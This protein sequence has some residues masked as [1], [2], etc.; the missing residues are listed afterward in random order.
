MAV[1]TQ[2][3]IQFIFRLSFGISVAMAITPSRLVTSGFYRIHLWVVMGLNTLAAI[4]IYSA[5]SSLIESQIPT[6]LVLSGAIGTAVLCYV[7]AALWLFEKKRMGTNLLW[8]AALLTLLCAALA[9]PWSRQTTGWGI[10]MALMDLTSGGLLLGSTLTA[11][12]LGHWYLNTP[13]MDLVPLRRLILWMG[14]SVVARSFLCA[15]GLGLQLAWQLDLSS[16]VWTFIVFRWV[17]GLLGTGAMAWMAWL[18]LKVP[19]TQSATGILYT[20][21]ILAF[22]GELVSQLLSV[23]LLYPV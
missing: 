13:T 16:T 19:N 10:A 18:T 1:L 15:A 12:F 3:L 9:T 4:F 2:V 6:G 8:T 7:A 23:D 17:A 11:M 21:V 22:I 20:G 14:V 5:S